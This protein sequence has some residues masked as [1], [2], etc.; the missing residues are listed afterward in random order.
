MLPELP[1]IYLIVSA[2]PE[3]SLVKQR[4][5]AITTTATDEF[6]SHHLLDLVELVFLGVQA[7]PSAGTAE[8]I[9]RIQGPQPSFPS[10]PRTREVDLRVT[11]GASLLTYL[12]EPPD[13]EGALCEVTAALLQAASGL[14]KTATEGKY[15]S[16]LDLLRN[17]AKMF[18]DARGAE[19]RERVPVPAASV[20]GSD[21]NSLAAS[22]ATAVRALGDVLEA[23]MRIDREEL[24]VLWWVFGKH[25]RSL[26]N[27]YCEASVGSACIAS[28]VD[29]KSLMLTP[30][31]PASSDFFRTVLDDRPSLTLGQ[32][33]ADA[34]VEMLKLLKTEDLVTVL[35]QSH[36]SVTPLT[37]LAGR[38]IES[39]KSPWE[40]EFEKRTRVSANDSQAAWFWASHLLAEQV[41]I[42]LIKRDLLTKDAQ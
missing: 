3:D 11:A 34:S 39:E 22:A 23:N 20:K 33:I 4:A 40:T 41:A 30:P 6:I 13:N 10:D 42:D 18:L 25:S 17:A 24:Q 5:G 7:Q 35:V 26:G 16:L 12:K 37:W 19:V 15:G 31:I 27:P 8:L 14:R 1:D 2:Q 38:L 28:A 36:P 32:L 9:K 29:L 21:V